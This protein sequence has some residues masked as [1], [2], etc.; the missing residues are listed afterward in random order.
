[1]TAGKEVYKLVA[2]FVDQ[3]IENPV[4]ERIGLGSAL[5]CLLGHGTAEPVAHHRLTFVVPSCWLK[6][7]RLPCVLHSRWPDLMPRLCPRGNSR[8][9]EQRVLKYPLEIGR[10][11]RIRKTTTAKPEPNEKFAMSCPVVPALSIPR[12]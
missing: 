12:H 7:D 1:M 6:D 3:Q 10:V 11:A 2:G 8:V 5:A 4:I 9:C